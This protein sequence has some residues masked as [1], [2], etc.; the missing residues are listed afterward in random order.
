LN[1]VLCGLSLQALPY[2]PLTVGRECPVRLFFCMSHG[3]RLLLKGIALQGRSAFRF[4]LFSPSINPQLLAFPF[5]EFVS[6]DEANVLPVHGSIFL[7]SCNL[8]H[9]PPG[10]PFSLSPW[11]SPVAFRIS[12]GWYN[13]FVFLGGVPPAREE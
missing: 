12:Q 6:F 8:E 7:F 4:S 1:P 9:F 10:L 2:A 13:C 5:F 11:T 3:W